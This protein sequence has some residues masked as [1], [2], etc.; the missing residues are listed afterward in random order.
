LISSGRTP[1]ITRPSRIA[2]RSTTDPASLSARYEDVLKPIES[3][4]EIISSNTIDLGD[5]EDSDHSDN[6]ATIT[7]PSPTTA[8]IVLD[9]DSD[10]LSDL[11]VR[12]TTIRLPERRRLNDASTNT[13]NSA[14]PT[15]NSPPK[16][17]P[18]VRILIT[19]DIPGTNPLLVS[20]KLSQ[21]LKDVRLAWVTRQQFPEGITPDVVFLTYRNRRLWDLTTCKSIGLEVD[22]HGNIRQ[23]DHE[24]DVFDDMDDKVHLVAATK[25]ILVE[26]KRRAETAIQESKP[27]VEEVIE[28][29][30]V[31]ESPR[32]R[33]ILEPRGK[34]KF[35]LSVKAVS[36]ILLTI[37]M[38]L[39]ITL[40]HLGHY[41]RGDRAR[42]SSQLQTFCRRASVPHVRR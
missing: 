39:L 27:A 8:P 13:P 17:D 35:K 12:S 20:R 42:M 4:T 37:T 5:S 21:N 41:F 38:T 16:P 18:I 22:A 2:T 26:M 33:V 31:E 32:I 24:N 11:E 1:Q 14:T 19:S 6:P 25:E 28:E 9:D 30:V 7:V 15:A 29:E 34:E 10:A 23:K 40:L 3:R 36:L